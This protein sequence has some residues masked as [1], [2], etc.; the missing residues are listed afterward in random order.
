[1]ELTFEFIKMC[2]GNAWS[3]YEN[4]IKKYI[5]QL[6][7]KTLEMQIKY[8][9]SENAREKNKETRKKSWVVITV[10]LLAPYFSH[11]LCFLTQNF[12]LPMLLQCPSPG[13]LSDNTC[14]KF[15]RELA[16]NHLRFFSSEISYL[17]YIATVS[18]GQVIVDIF[19]WDDQ[20][21]TMLEMKEL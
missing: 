9:R 4:N 8:L 16:C 20:R 7:N 15:Y 1:M 14:S 19:C 21:I 12:Q 6:I 3:K 10:L 18:I 13:P 17:V 11:R 5:K 2:Q